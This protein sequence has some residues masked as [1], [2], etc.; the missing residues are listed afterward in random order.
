[1]PVQAEIAADD[2]TI[3]VVDLDGTLIATDLLYESFWSALSE[4]FRSFA[5]AAIHLL[6]G[7][8]HLKDFLARRVTIDPALL[9]Y[10][11]GVLELIR[12]W[13]AKGGRTA[14]VTAS[15]QKF[16]QSIA[17]Y[18]GLFDEVHASD[19]LRNL[20][21]PV[22]A[23]F[24][25]ER[26]G[27]GN[28]DYIGDSKADLP[29]WQSARRAITGASK[30]LRRSVD[31]IS[32]NV[33][34][35][36]RVAVSR[37][38]Y[39]KALRP[40]Q[41][42]KNIL[43]FL[44]AIAAHD[45]SATTWIAALLAFIAFSLMASSVYVLN[46][47]LDLAADRAHPR[48]QLRPL[49]SGAV[50]LAHGS[51]LVPVLFLFGLLFALAVGRVEFIAILLAYYVLTTAYSVSLKRRLV[52][53][54]FTLAGL[55]TMRVLAGGVATGV[56]LSVWLLAFSIFFFLSLAA[57]KRQAELVDGRQ[58]GRE[59]AAGRAYH[60]DDLPVV[61]MMGISAGYV[62]TLVL[63]LYLNS[64][65]VQELY[66][67]PDILWAVCLILLYWISRMVMIAHRGSMD[68]DPIVFAARDR[69]S[70]ICG[71][72]ILGTILAGALL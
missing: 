11:E 54:I 34:H 29:A 71:I 30:T 22:K 23:A 65:A 39:V 4:D 9:P 8:A 1:M 49:A 5:G 51:L 35:L 60:V 40:H 27:K 52:I 68:D 25:R 56:P 72:A 44:P 19:G 70:Q 10:N 66:T 63:A 26:F 18:L 48:K 24:L 61:S 14:L 6:R 20:K 43:I 3:L 16:A 58:S 42:V 12:S 59:Q 36:E 47:L 38:A 2:Q 33:L 46:D 37:L 28:Y 31:A 62:A 45:L 69:A 32:A 41:W 64:S 67:N 15:D 50:S 55:Y 7:K 53:D 57:V 13:R 21:G 17:D